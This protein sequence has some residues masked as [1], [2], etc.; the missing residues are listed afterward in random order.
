MLL[1]TDKTFAELHADGESFR[2]AMLDIQKYSTDRQE[3]LGWISRMRFLAPISSDFNLGKKFMELP[4]TPETTMGANCKCA[5]IPAFQPGQRHFRLTEAGEMSGCQ[6]FVAVSYYWQR[7]PKRQLN[8]DGATE[9]FVKTRSGMRTGRAPIDVIDRAV[10]FAASHD[11]GLIWIDQEVIDQDDPWDKSQGIQVMDIVYERSLW[12]VAILDTTIVSQDQLDMLDTIFGM[13]HE[14]NDEEDGEEDGEEEDEEDDEEVDEEVDEEA[15]EEADDEVEDEVEEA[16]EENVE[17]EVDYKSASNVI[18]LLELLSSDLY[19]TRAW[20][21]QESL[22]SLNMRVL[23]QVAPNIKVPPQLSP[24]YHT[25][26]ICYAMID[27]SFALENFVGAHKGRSSLRAKTDQFSTVICPAF[28]EA[29]SRRLSRSAAEVLAMLETRSN[30]ILSD[31]LA[32][33]ANLCAYGRRIDTAALENTDHGFSTAVLVLSL[34]NG[35]L[36][37]LSGYGESFSSAPQSF[38]GPMRPHRYL[39][40]WQDDLEFNAKTFGWGWGP[41]D[42]GRLKSLPYCEMRVLDTQLLRI[43]PATLIPHGLW[44]SGFLWKN[45]TDVDFQFLKEEYKKDKQEIIDSESAKAIKWQVLRSFAQQGHWK[46]AEALWRFECYDGDYPTHGNKGYRPYALTEVLD[47]ETYELKDFGDPWIRS[48]LDCGLFFRRE[49]T[50]W[51]LQYSAVDDGYV[52][53]W[54]CVSSSG[55]D[56]E[57]RAAFENSTEDYGDEQ[58]DFFVFTPFIQSDWRQ[59]DIS[60]E[61]ATMSW[62]VSRTGQYHHGVEVL[63]CERKV[64]GFWIVDGLETKSFVLS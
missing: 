20:T 5:G 9:Y 28:A 22:S 30:A 60:P 8:P 56:G 14:E 4:D 40:L 41:P 43:S 62:I 23:I 38:L 3:A 49:T 64:E 21:L 33:I 12:P 59:F 13:V 18:D 17:E 57:P 19:Y 45:E 16:V 35:D 24:M 44:T 25:G 54:T 39:W 29:P 51:W 7:S 31:R 47:S 10:A 32:I 27:F 48:D 6:H 11:L 53:A 55:D 46:L 52:T 1:D 37:L 26:D 2:A 36:T 15:D 61:Y 42:R 50:S 63:K 34:I 58:G